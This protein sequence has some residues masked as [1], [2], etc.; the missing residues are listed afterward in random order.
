M[1]ETVPS[2]NY[3]LISKDHLKR[4]Y[5]F[6]TYISLTAYLNMLQTWF[7]PQLHEGGLKATAVVQQ[8]SAPA[9]YALKATKISGRQ[10]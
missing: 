8:D 5:F 3:F 9:H 7:V 6:D 1:R 10:I 2:D 4:P